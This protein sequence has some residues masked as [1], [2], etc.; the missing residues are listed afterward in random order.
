MWTK[1]YFPCFTSLFGGSYLDGSISTC[2]RLTRTYLKLVRL[3]EN[4]EEIC[5]KW[6]S[7]LALKNGS[8]VGSSPITSRLEATV[9]S[10]FDK[11]IELSFIT[12]KYDISSWLQAVNCSWSNSCPKSDLV[13]EN[14]RILPSQKSPDNLL[15]SK[16]GEILRLHRCVC[17]YVCEWVCRQCI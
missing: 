16:T 8:T 12:T 5:E 1:S 14:T 6:I 10:G 7:A 15:T 17:M 3:I 13:Y 2:G 11:L 9:S 4:G